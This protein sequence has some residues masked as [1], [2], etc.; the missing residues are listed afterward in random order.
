MAKVQAYVSDTVYDNIRNIVKERHQEGVKDVTI[1]NV[2]S[3]LLELGLRVYKIQTERKEGGFNQREFNKVLLDQVVK[4]NATCTHLL[5]IGV[6]N[7]EVAG[8]ESFELERLV[9]QVRSHSANVIGNFFEDT[10][11]AEK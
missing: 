1:S 11:D 3:M 5:R 6:L 9:E 7:Q 10:V 2:S 8:K 4:I